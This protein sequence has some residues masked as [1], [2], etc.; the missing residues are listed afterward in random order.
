MP[1]GVPGSSFDETSLGDETIEVCDAACQTEFTDSETQSNH[2]DLTTSGDIVKSQDSMDSDMRSNTLSRSV[3]NQSVDRVGSSTI[4]NNLLRRPDGASDPNL[5]KELISPTEITKP[6][7]TSS[8]SSTLP[9]KTQLQSVAVCE[10]INERLN[11]NNILGTPVKLQPYLTCS[12]VFGRKHVPLPTKCEEPAPAGPPAAEAEV[13]V[14]AEVSEKQA[15]TLESSKV[16]KGRSF[17]SSQKSQSL[18]LAPSEAK[19]AAQ[20]SPTKK[21]TK[22]SKLPSLLGRK[23][24]SKVAQPTQLPRKT[25]SDTKKVGYPA[26][27]YTPFHPKQSHS[28]ALRNGLLSP[29]CF[30]LYPL[31]LCVDWF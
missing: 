16:S 31:H 14:Q 18:D 23:D 26:A 25:D 24:K 10:T 27:A 3:Q 21:P 6:R 9:R 7:L 12:P 29:L 11:N 22:T 19:K 20:Q 4:G 17:F 8:R 1:S 2:N 15:S 5:H 13:L 28:A 30:Y